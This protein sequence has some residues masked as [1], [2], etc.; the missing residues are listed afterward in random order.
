M[1][2]S[3]F[4]ICLSAVCQHQLNDH[5]A[6]IPI[7]CKQKLLEF[8]TN[9]DQLST[10]DCDRLVSSPSFADNLTELKFY[11]SEDLSDSMLA[12]LT[13]NNKRLE[14]IT[15]VECPRVT[16]KGVRTVTSGQKNLLQLELRA[17]YQLTD[18]GLTDV[19]CP[20]LHTVDISG[21]ARVTSLGIRFLVQRN[22]NIHCLYLNHCRSLD[23]QALYDIAYYVGERLRV[24]ELDFLPSLADPAAALQHLST[25]CP[26]VCQLSLARFFNESYD[27]FPPA[28]QFKIDGFNLRD[29]DLYGNYF[30][31]LPELPPTV[32]SLRLSVNGDENPFELVLELDFLPSLADPAAALQH[33]STQ[34]P[35][36]CQLSLARFF[37][38][39]YDD[40]PPAVQFKI[41]GFNL[42]DIDLYGNYFVILPELPPTVH[43]LRLSVNGDENPFELVRSL[44]AQPFLKSI[45]LQLTIREASIAAIDNANTLLSTILP[46]IGN[47][48]TILTVATPRLFDDSLRLITE[49]TPNLTHLALDVNHLSTHILQRGA[50][51]Q[52][53][54]LRSL[55]ICRMRI[56]YRVLFA[57]ARGA[58]N[59][60]DLET[61]QMLSVDDRFLAILGEN[62]R[63]LRCIN[64]NGC[65]WVSDKGMAA[66][67]RRCPLRE[68]RIRGTACTDQSIYTLAQFCPDL[69]WISYADYSEQ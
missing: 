30:V 59:L 52:G 27:D 9:H 5:L 42:R 2:K 37:N 33:L 54:R 38:E 6:L 3:L 69:E 43:S 49:C 26:N 51:S 23:D 44:E 19:H 31:I 40:F 8:F 68:V 16:D 45:N 61:S 21:C 53:S 55:K 25:Q 62:C 48:I 63:Q 18:A 46:Y 58:R 36:V 35:N 41:D 32:H 57:I 50:K 34:C 65:R 4:N 20:F 11:L 28:V 39:S 14:R 22:P 60:L 56:T 13:A 10:L 66:L 7:E 15:L 64:L 47:K 17:M 12:A 1:V 67:A 24:L 29:I